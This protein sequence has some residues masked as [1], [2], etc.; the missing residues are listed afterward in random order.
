VR[1]IISPK[2]SKVTPLNSQEKREEV[3]SFDFSE[4]GD[5]DGNDSQT[6]ISPATTTTR[7]EA[8]KKDHNYNKESTTTPGLTPILA[9]TPVT[10][11]ATHPTAAT[12]IT[13]A[14]KIDAIYDAIS[15]GKEKKSFLEGKKFDAIYETLRLSKECPIGV[16]PPVYKVFLDEVQADKIQRAVH[17]AQLTA[18]P[19]VGFDTNVWE[20]IDDSVKVLIL[21]TI[22]KDKVKKKS[23]V[24]K[25][26]SFEENDLEFDGSINSMALICALVLTV[27]FGIAAIFNTDY[28]NQITTMMENCPEDCKMFEYFQTTSVNAIVDNMQ[29]TTVSYVAMAI[30]SSLAG[31]VF[32]AMY[33]LFR[34]SGTSTQW[35]PQL[36]K[37]IKVLSVCVFICTFSAV[38]GVL[39]VTGVI[40]KFVVTTESRVCETAAG[41][42][43]VV[44]IFAVSCSFVGGVLLML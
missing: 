21:E 7:S 44:G 25:F 29:S 24:L 36:L 28:Y 35:P 31:L 41:S 8:N 38:V 20:N 6:V 4:D 10:S 26:F 43:A 33:N 32:S 12:T 19:P 9:T 11:P 40:L 42:A 23:N 14:D 18:Y 16:S 39:C 27:P 30:Y 3:P 2:M 1:K 5:Y 13:F 34:P 15:T 22:F 37:K 17:L